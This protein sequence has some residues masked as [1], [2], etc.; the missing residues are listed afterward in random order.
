MIAGYRRGTVDTVVNSA[1]YVLLAF[2][3]LVA[4]IAIVTF[5][6]TSCG[7]SPS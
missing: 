2:P 5:W 6:A 1:S 7:R 4:V 3:A